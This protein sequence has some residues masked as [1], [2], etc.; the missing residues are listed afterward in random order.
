[1]SVDT[2][3][4][5]RELGLSLASVQPV[6]EGVRV[7]IAI[8]AGRQ[9]VPLAWL[10]PRAAA[11]TTAG[12]DVRVFLTTAPPVV[13]APAPSVGQLAGLVTQAFD[14]GTSTVAALAPDILEPA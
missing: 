13:E 6:A 7:V 1:M 11:E 2:A 8:P 12:Y 3:D 4:A 14:D 5:A 10:E 9:L